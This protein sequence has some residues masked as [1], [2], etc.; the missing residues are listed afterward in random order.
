MFLLKF[1]PLKIDI[2][3]S[4]IESVH[5]II[6]ICTV[7][8]GSSHI[9]TKSFCSKGQMDF[10]Y[11]SNVHTGRHTER[12]EYDIQ[13]PAIGQIGHIFHRQHSGNN[14]FI[15]MT[16]RHLIAYRNLSLLG[17][18]NTH[19]L[20]YARRQFIP[21]F[22]RKHFCIHYNTIFTMRHFQGCIPHFTSLFSKDRPQQPLL[23][24]Q[25][26]LPFGGHFP[27]KDIA[28]PDFRTDT[29]DSPLVQVF[30]GLI[31]HARHIT[32]DFL[33]AQLRISGLRLIFFNVHGSID[34]IPYQFFTQ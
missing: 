1:T 7:K 24:C 10:Q 21:V 23:R 18:I 9:E 34:I 33:C 12:I 11:L 5:N 27:H 15:S 13:R 30:Q 22:P 8:H 6:F 4:Q 17:N 32:G 31:S 28:G 3:I 25:L 29:D 19:S 14:T 2:I 16:S 20:I 26:C